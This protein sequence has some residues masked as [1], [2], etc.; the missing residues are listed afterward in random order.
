MEGILFSLITVLAWGSWLAPSQNVPLESQHTRTFFVT[1]AVLVLSIFV[2]SLYGFDGLSL[3]QCLSPFIGGLIWA[4]GGYCAFSAVSKIGMARAFGIWAPLNIVT[5]IIWGIFLFEEFINTST[6]NIVKGVAYLV[7][8]V[9]GL[10]FI[11][12]SGD[13][14][15][16][17]TNIKKSSTNGVFLAILAGIL[18]GSYFIPIQLEKTTLTMWVAT[19]PLAMGMFTGSLILV[20]IT[21]SSIKLKRQK[22]Y[23]QV[24]STGLLW[25]IGNYGALRMMEII[26]TGKGYTIAQ[27]CVVVNALIGIFVFKNPKPKS[28]VALYTFIGIALATLGGILLGSIES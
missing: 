2:G 21:R 18:L 28:K 8:I 17:S 14:N 20:L 19:F 1:L 27:L 11:I 25:A 9:I 5:S 12:F 4:V 16:E 6:Q 22:H 13:V 24:I 10:M 15:E 26:G 3:K 23:F 7:I